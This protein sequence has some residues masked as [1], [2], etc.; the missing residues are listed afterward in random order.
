M[1]VGRLFEHRESLATV[2]AMTEPA[3]AYGSVFF[4]RLNSD[5]AVTNW[6]LFRFG[7]TAAIVTSGFSPPFFGQEGDPVRNSELA[8]LLGSVAEL[9]RGWRDRSTSWHLDA[10]RHSEWWQLSGSAT[11]RSTPL[12]DRSRR[13]RPHCMA[14]EAEGTEV[15]GVTPSDTLNL[16]R[17]ASR[18]CRLWA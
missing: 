2:D 1:V 14:Q 13:S 12:R 16:I 6:S 5:S 9:E 15:R 18:I 8:Y 7:E 17:P 11:R 4:L 10:F 3:V